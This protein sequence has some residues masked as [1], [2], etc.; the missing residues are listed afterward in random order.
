MSVDTLPVTMSNKHK[1]HRLNIIRM[2]IQED[3]TLV[4]KKS[5]HKAMMKLKEEIELDYRKFAGTGRSMKLSFQNG[6]KFIKVTKDNSVWGFIVKKNGYH[7]N[8]RVVP[9]DVL[10][11]ASWRAPAKWVRGNIYDTSLHWDWLRWTGPIYL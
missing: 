6:R 11:A 9:G 2:S 8:E 3:K 5:F 7:K 10:K 4:D 1:S